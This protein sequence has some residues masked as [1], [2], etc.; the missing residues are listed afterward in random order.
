[1]YNDSNIAIN[2]LAV[3]KPEKEPRRYTLAEY[4]RREERSEELHEYYDGHIVKLPNANAPHNIITVNIATALHSALKK[5]DEKFIVLMGKQL[6]YLPNQNYALYPDVVMLN[7]P[8]QYFDYNET[9]IINPILIVE[10]QSKGIKRLERNTKFHEYKTL[11]S[12]KEHILI[13][14]QKCYV[15][16]SFRE[17]PDLWREKKYTE[18]TD[19][20]CLKSVDCHI[21]MSMIYRKIEFK[22]K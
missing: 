13:D 14:K 20:V 3:L 21:D 18:L 5:I 8:P 17:E 12:F 19:S 1:M 10:I 4:L 6:L 11:L 9:L 7:S 22:N 16:V 15:Q 2:P